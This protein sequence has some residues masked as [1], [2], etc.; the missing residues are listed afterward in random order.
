MEYNYWGGGAAAL[1]HPLKY[2]PAFLHTFY[3]QSEIINVDHC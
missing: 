2:G 1:Q 3:F